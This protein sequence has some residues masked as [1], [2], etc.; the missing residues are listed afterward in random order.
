M[1]YSAFHGTLR[2]PSSRRQV[3]LSCCRALHLPSQI[4]QPGPVLDIPPFSLVSCFDRAAVKPS[5]SSNTKGMA[6]VPQSC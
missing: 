4:S 6:I 3:E 2:L 1:A 5:A